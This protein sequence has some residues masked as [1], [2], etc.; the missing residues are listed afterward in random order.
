MTFHVQGT[1]IYST[2]AVTYLDKAYVSSVVSGNT[3]VA[4]T[5]E[6]VDGT[7]SCAKQAGTAT[8]GSWVEDFSQKPSNFR[9]TGRRAPITG[10]GTLTIRFSPGTSSW[11]GFAIA[12]AAL[13]SSPFQDSSYS[14]AN[15]ANETTTVLTMAVSGIAYGLACEEAGLITRSESHTS[16]FEENDG[17][18]NFTFGTQ[19]ADNISADVTLT[20]TIS[21][22]SLWSAFGITYKGKAGGAYTLTAEKGTFTETGNAAGLK[23]AR[24]M[25]AALGTYTETGV[26]VGLRRGYTIATVL[27]TFAEVGLAIGLRCARKLPAAVGTFAEVGLAT[28]LCCARKLPAAVGT[29]AFTGNAADLIYTP[30]GIH[31]YTITA[32]VGAFVFSGQVTALRAARQMTAAT[33]A[34]AES[35]KAVNL[36]CVRRLTTVVG[37][38][39][40]TGNAAT[41]TYTPVGAAYTL[42]AVTG[43]FSEVGIAAALRAARQL[44]AV[45]GTFAEAGQ[46]VN[47]VCVRRLTAVLG[48]YSLSGK[49][50]NLVK[51]GAYILSAGT[52]AYNWSGLDATLRTARR[53]TAAAGTFTLTGLPAV[54][55]RGR[56]LTAALGTY[57]ETGLPVGLRAARRLPVESCAYSLIMWPADLSK[58]PPDYIPPQDERTL[59]LLRRGRV[60]MPDVG[61]REMVLTK[62][63]RTYHVD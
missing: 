21:A 55:F 41:L 38:F 39:I 47:L 30:V 16:L 8:L 52:G 50:V 15:S 35:G 36:I 9:M 17:A 20:W 26:A 25:A 7:A 49:D 44:P 2:T 18:H 22:S 14:N 61:G 60:F 54:L 11:C 24:K 37:A 19:Y 53:M 58:Y 12:E 3:V 6:W 28:G 45:A 4:L 48:T 42:T 1:G 27:G 33:G 40:F 56:T 63:A 13:D 59:N 5:S 51:T 29:F 34:I 23:A 46:T 32:V 57:V 10:N 31:H 43:A 62:Q